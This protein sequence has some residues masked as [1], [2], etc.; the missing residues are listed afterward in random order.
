VILPIKGGVSHM[1]QRKKI[2]VVDDDE[3]WLSTIKDILEFNYD[4][5]CLADPTKTEELLLTN[6][7]DLLI[8]DKSLAGI[9]GLEVLSRLR[10]TSPDLRAIMLTGFPDV[11]SAV[12]SMKLGAVDYISKGTRD[13]ENTLKLRVK[14][15]LEK[16][17]HS[18]TEPSETREPWSETPAIV[19]LINKG[20]NAELEFKSS[21]RWDIR[22]K[23]V[24]KELEKVI[25]KTVAGF[26]NSEN[27]G[28]L[29]IGVDDN[30]T[31]LGLY[32]DYQS[33][34]KKD[35]DGYENFLTTLMLDTYGKEFSPFIQIIF[36]QVDDKEICQIIIHSSSKPAFVPDERGAQNL[37]YIRTGNSTRLLSTKEVLEYCK[38]R[39]KS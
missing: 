5:T 35:R 36:H 34:K 23:K 13:L 38:I 16:R 29:L 31:I 32:E 4:L 24:N 19:S 12:D 10:K 6:S 8:L 7:Y 3:R 26:L 37:F 11:D 20:E 14:E 2:L 25:L 22:Q 39:W 15:A 9:S 17:I 28:T 1:N 30:G 18:H 27:G 33:M 21:T